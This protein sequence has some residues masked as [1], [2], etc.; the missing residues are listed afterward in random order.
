MEYIPCIRYSLV[1][2]GANSNGC[3]VVPEKYFAF[4][5]P[6]PCRASMSTVVGV[7]WRRSCSY[8]ARGG[9]GTLYFMLLN[10]IKTEIETYRKPVLF[11]YIGVVRY[12]MSSI[13][14]ELR[15]GPNTCSF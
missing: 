4:K 12:L 10:S 8:D 5:S 15:H 1:V 7:L 6:V 3:G 11:K 13:C 2:L 14:E 9:G